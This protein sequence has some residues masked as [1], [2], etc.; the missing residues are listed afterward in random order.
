MKNRRIVIKFI[1]SV[2][3]L[4]VKGKSKVRDKIK[5]LKGVKV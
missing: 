1:S 2:I 4:S 3:I 5:E